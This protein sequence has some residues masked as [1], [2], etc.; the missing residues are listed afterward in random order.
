MRKSFSKFKEAKI[1]SYLKLGYIPIANPQDLDNINTTAIKVYAE[2]TIWEGLYRGGL[3]NNYIQV[4]D[5][6]FDC[7]EK[8]EPIGSIDK[9][10]F[11]GIYNAGGFSIVNLIIDK[12][13]Q[14]GVGLFGYIA[15]G[16]IRN[17]VIEGAFIN[18]YD[19]VGGLVGKSDTIKISNCSFSGEIKGKT[20]N[21]GG[22]VGILDNSSIRDSMSKVFIDGDSCVG[23][24]VGRSNNSTI[25]N[26]TSYGQIKANTMQAGGI[27][28]MS[29]NSNIKDS[30]AYARVRATEQASGICGFMVD[31][32]IERCVSN[33]EILSNDVL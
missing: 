2:G 29:N 6:I 31:T 8:V 28:G 26:A 12:E 25:S 15:K 21:V 1:N 11:S 7:E 22:L 3:R 5:I 13:N 24:I 23:G 14:D 17:L 27:V 19:G 4:D 32:T 33:N 18:G 30:K 20:D 10:P 9:G 16:T